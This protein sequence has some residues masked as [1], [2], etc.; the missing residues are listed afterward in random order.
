MGLNEYNRKRKFS[1]TP[2]PAGVSRVARQ[3]SNRKM[4]SPTEGKAFV[5]QK[6]R[7]T[8]LHYDFR[9]ED[10]S[11][12][13]KSWAVPKGPSLDPQVKRLAVL[14]EDHPY[15][16]L[17]FEGIIPEGNYGAG[18]VIVW[19]HGTYTTAKPLLDQFKEG[20]ISFELHG[21]KLH[22]RFSLVKTKKENQWLLIKT[23]DEFA[24]SNDL[25]NTSPYSVLSNR[26]ND[27]L[28]RIPSQKVVVSTR[29]PSNGRSTAIPLLIA[30]KWK[31]NKNMDNNPK[32]ISAQ[33]LPSKVRPM[34]AYPVDNSFDSK[35]WAFEVKWDGVRA[36]SYVKNGTVRIQSRNGNNITQKYPEI[37]I[38]LETLTTNIRSAVFDGEIVVLD[39][40]GLPN[41]Q[42]HQRRMH[43]NDE[44]EIKTLSKEIPAI[45]YLFDILYLDGNDLRT[46]SYLSRREILAQAMCAAPNDLL[47]ISD[48]VE[49]RGREMLKHTLNFN[50]EGIVAKRKASHYHEGMRSKEWLKIKNIRTQDCVV[51]G[52]TEG[53]GNRRNAFGSLLLA[54]YN[55]KDK[56]YDFVGHVGSGFDHQAVR[57]IYSKLQNIR[58]D[59][60]P[61]K[62]LP[63]K[64]RR[65]TWVKPVLVA[66]V[67]FT[68]W[69]KD[70]I[71]RAPIFLGFRSDKSPQ[72]CILEADQPVPSETI[73][74]SATTNDESQTEN[75]PSKGN[76]CNTTSAT[77]T[78]TTNKTTRAKLEFSNLDKIYWPAINGQKPITKGDLISYY[79]SISE[80]ILPHL[81]DR[82]LSLSR[83][84]NGIHGKS[85]YHKDWN[86]SRP[87]Y[88][89]TAKV[90]SEQRNA[91]I[92]YLVCNNI[93]SLLWIANLGA[94]EMHPWY[95]RIEDL[96]H[97]KTSRLL[98]DEKCG[99]NLPDF[100]VLDL[101]PYIY[102]GKERAGDEPE[103]NLR[104]FR[105][106]TEVAFDLKDVLDQLHI[107]SFVKSSGKTGLHIY[108]P[109]IPKFSYDQTR[110]FAEI[111]GKIL[112][113][114]IP[115]KITM[116]W[117]TAKRKGKVFFDYNQNSRGKTIAS[118]WSVRPTPLATVS[119]PIGW[120]NL[121][122]FN[123]K[124]F[125]LRTVP[126]IFK[127][128]KDP[129]RGVIDDKQDLTKI[130]TAMKALA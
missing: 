30:T 21:K 2:E 22:G 88:V 7:A 60:M 14:T 120:K 124:D 40:R 50:L 128:R 102:S 127:S 35:D 106:A 48:Y 38:A 101:D 29:S 108:I 86:Q 52:F 81:R 62:T 90:Y 93:Q 19:D 91:A 49:E 37:S 4:N 65:T 84:P 111:L 76:Q 8:R 5:F 39:E 34:L 92:N 18:T 80:L 64:N 126:N 67:K 129:W 73:L 51:V 72:E 119:V 58:T 74:K 53:E 45:Y 16:Y 121:D 115:N 9:L 109:T 42:G 89:K 59:T 54:V 79:E 61:I 69:T 78:L 36:I 23:R 56:S 12:A 71:M 57:D 3:V 13:L 44:Q 26:N 66:E 103:F 94:I 1:K 123:P 97:C 110:S 10:E 107:I 114:K 43:V 47:K 63:Y 20:K 11:G 96:E 100:V 99:L 105:A 33:Q 98:Y 31:K 46:Q 118:I 28:E 6:H 27:D 41:F 113:S 95:S 130:I 85:F 70:G 117:S 82:P 122:N 75:D 77:D 104:A 83:Y 116:E 25:T 15:D 24:T 112:M 87:S 125:T 68:Q 55:T 32:S 17:L